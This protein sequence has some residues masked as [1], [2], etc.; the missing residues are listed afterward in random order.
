MLIIAPICSVR[1]EFSVLKRIED[2]WID[3]QAGRQTG[4]R[5]KIKVK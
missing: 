1:N 2:G 5:K 4:G 3:R